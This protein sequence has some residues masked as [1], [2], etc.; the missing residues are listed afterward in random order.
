MVGIF[1]YYKAFSV[2]KASIAAAVS[3]IYPIITVFIGILIFAESISFIQGVSIGLMI[4]GVILT[5]LN[6]KKLSFK[7]AAKIEKGLGFALFAALIFGILF[8]LFD[9]LV[10]KF[11][12]FFATLYVQAAAVFFLVLYLTTKRENIAVKNKSEI[13]IFSAIGLF[14]T[15]AFVAVAKGF[16]IGLVSIVTPVSSLYPAVI[17]ILSWLFLKERLASNQIIGIIGILI[18]LFLLAS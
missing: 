7:S 14:N 15:V 5:S 8:A 13:Y 2:N 12:A 4:L 16:E 17:I 1:L 18:G 3:A 10:N 9:I 11:G 6:L